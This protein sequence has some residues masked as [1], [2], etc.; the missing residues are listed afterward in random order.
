MVDQGTAEG[1][2]VLLKNA[3]HHAY[4]R[5]YKQK[6]YMRKGLMDNITIDL[7]TVAN[8]LARYGIDVL[9]IKEQTRQ[10]YKA[11]ILDDVLKHMGTESLGLFG[12]VTQIKQWVSLLDEHYE[13]KGA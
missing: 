7:M 6:S 2:K 4:V 13:E 9:A 1:A 8:D 11:G 10:E 3:V 5:V 12:L